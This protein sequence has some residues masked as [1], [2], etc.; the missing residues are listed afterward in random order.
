MTRAELLTPKQLERLRE[1]D[2]EYQKRKYQLNREARIKSV[3]EYNKKYPERY[4]ARYI[5]GN[6][7]KLKKIKREKCHCGKK[8][9][10][11]HP[12]Y[13]IPLKVLW[14]CASHHKLLLLK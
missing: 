11:H 13:N 14:L 10:G 2:R 7:I 6:A 3:E 1:M 8:G 5:L 4:R 12:N 9:Q